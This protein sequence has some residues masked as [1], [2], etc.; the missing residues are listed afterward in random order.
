MKTALKY[1]SVLLLLVLLSGCGV[2]SSVEELLVAPSLDESQKAVLSALEQRHP[3]R[4][5]FVYPF[6]G[7]NRSAI[8]KYD[9]DSDGSDE[10]LVFFRD[11][12]E[13]LNA[14]LSVLEQR[15]D[16][17]YYVSS[18]EEGFG[19][20]VN[21]VFYLSSAASENVILVE[22]SSP[23]KSSNTISVYTYS[24]NQLGIGFEENSLDLL[25]LDLD[26][27]DYSEFCYLV[28][29]SNE[30][31]FALKY[32]RS[33]EGT[34]FSRSQFNLRSSTIGVESLSQGV[35]KSGE[36]AIF[37][38]EVSETSLQTEIFLLSEDK[39]RLI[40]AEELIDSLD[41]VKLSQRAT[42]SG[43]K[44]IDIE[45]I[46]CFPSSTAPSQNVFAPAS[47]TY[48]YTLDGS[49]IVHVRTAYYSEGTR[50]LRAG[51]ASLTSACVPRPGAGDREG[52]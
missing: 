34:I 10:I 2:T 48:F 41:L 21:S 38:D 12:S 32:V 52:A 9:I 37:V 44:C 33:A 50:I 11:S 43:L 23:N 6:T 25:I 8:Q 36:R 51:P 39:S 24:E 45:G 26:E 3:N 42:E 47:W 49:E 5:T 18:T 40:R 30:T 16:L 19:D 14:S 17:T 15:D 13:G 7:A 31:G 35:I 27:N 28:P 29:A 1:L 4:I 22:W 20:S 46:T